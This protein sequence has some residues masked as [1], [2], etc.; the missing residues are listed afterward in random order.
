MAQAGD[1]PAALP[2]RP[3]RLPS[4]GSRPKPATSH[5]HS[6]RLRQ[7]RRRQATGPAFADPGATAS[8][9]ACGSRRTGLKSPP[10]ELWRRPIGPGWSSFAVRGDLFYTQEQRGDDEV[11]AC[12]RGDHWRAGVETSRR[13]AVLRVKCEAPV[14]AGRRL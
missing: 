6:G 7:E 5:R 3:H 9:A 12:Y 11:V 10:V 4:N 13:G 1:Q 14:R 8:F 2:L